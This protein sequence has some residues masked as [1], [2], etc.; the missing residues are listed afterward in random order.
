MDS[1]INFIGSENLLK[2]IYPYV[3]TDAVHD[4]IIA[5]NK[6]HEMDEGFT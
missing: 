1:F 3:L 6:K 5:E 4:W 2:Y